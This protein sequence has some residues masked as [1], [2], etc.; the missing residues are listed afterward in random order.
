MNFSE[1]LNDI[2][3]IVEKEKYEKKKKEVFSTSYETA[4]ELYVKS[5]GADE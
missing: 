1:H 5:C 2:D 4:D 3:K